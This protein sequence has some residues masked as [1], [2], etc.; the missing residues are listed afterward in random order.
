MTE[1]KH[2]RKG[3]KALDPADPRLALSM[4][5]NV[6]CHAHGISRAMF[7]KLRDAGEAPDVFRVGRRVLVSAEAAE[8][9]RH[10]L[11]QAAAVATAV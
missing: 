8:R 2:T 5:I 6:F 10:R 11:E 7:Y 9:W 3:T 1:K 4:S